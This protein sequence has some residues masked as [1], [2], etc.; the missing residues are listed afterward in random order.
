MERFSR[1]KTL[2]FNG[3]GKTYLAVDKVNGKHYALKIIDISKMKPRDCDKEVIGERVV[4]KL[5]HPNI[6]RYELPFLTED[7]KNFVMITEYCEGR[8]FSQSDGT[9]AD[10]IRDYR[11]KNE[12]IPEKSVLDAILRISLGLQYLHN[13]NVVHADL[14]PE[15]ILVDTH[16]NI[17]V[18]DYATSLVFHNYTEYPFPVVGTYS[19]LSPEQMTSESF[20][21]SVDIWALGC[22]AH[23]ICCLKVQFLNH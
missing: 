4:D 1:Q 3:F 14:K 7:S 17:K 20:D 15:N 11:E 5:S 18:T 13:N 22:I 8:D 2:G 10:V 12:K 19:Y 23:E 6:V 16:G 21:K 9:M